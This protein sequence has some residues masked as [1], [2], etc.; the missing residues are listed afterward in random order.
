MFCKKRL[1]PIENKESDCEKERQ[2]RT[3]GGKPMKRESFVLAS[4]R[5]RAEAGSEGVTPWGFCMDVNIKGLR[6]DGF[7]SL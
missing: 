1:Q 4:L 5:I 3:R 2:E 6:E 7:V